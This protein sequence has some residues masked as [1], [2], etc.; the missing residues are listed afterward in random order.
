MMWAA[1]LI[2]LQGAQPAPPQ[3]TER[4][5]APSR[6]GACVEE[7]S[8]RRDDW[9]AGRPGAQRLGDLPA[10]E[11]VEAVLREVDRCES[12]APAPPAPRRPEK[13][14]G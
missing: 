9:S 5:G 13:P 1:A 14:A 6:W 10:G 11:L 2:L 8:W 12:A 4:T 3:Q 7:E